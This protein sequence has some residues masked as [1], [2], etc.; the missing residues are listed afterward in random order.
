[1]YIWIYL[2]IINI[3]VWFYTILYRCL[4]RRYDTQHSVYVLL[5]F[6]SSHRFIFSLKFKVCN[7]KRLENKGCVSECF[8]QLCDYLICLYS[9]SCKL[10]QTKIYCTLTEGPSG[11][12]SCNYFQTYTVLLWQVGILRHHGACSLAYWE[13][14]GKSCIIL[15]IIFWSS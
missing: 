2:G 11:V 9:N 10:S 13:S 5:L 12:H 3:N 4:T 15:K 14:K 7:L 8:A 1:M 6:S